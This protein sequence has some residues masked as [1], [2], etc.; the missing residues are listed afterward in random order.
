MKLPEGIE[1]K[2]GRLIV[3]LERC[4]PLQQ[5]GG[6]VEIRA[7]RLALVRGKKR[8]R[9]LCLTCPHKPKKNARVHLRGEGDAPTFR[10]A[11]HG[12]T[13]SR[14]GKATGKAKKHLPRLAVIR[15]GSRLTV[16]L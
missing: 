9:A 7:L 14:S 13:W 12:W 15:S 16:K 8:V 11:A 5:R 6:V 10:C 1:H 2:D 3:D 4:T